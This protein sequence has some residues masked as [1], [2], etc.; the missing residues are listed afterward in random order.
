M[1]DEFPLGEITI[2]P[3]GEPDVATKKQRKL[4]ERK[5]RKAHSSGRFATVI[6]AWD[7]QES[8]LS[9]EHPFVPFPEAAGIVNMA[10]VVVRGCIEEGGLPS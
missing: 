4:Q 3:D 8:V 6:L 5:A 10:E 9:I 2:F 7:R 1:S